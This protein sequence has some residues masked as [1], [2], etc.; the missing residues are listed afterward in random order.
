ML[1]DAPPPDYKRLNRDDTFAFSCHPGLTCFNTCCREKHLPLTPYDV[2]RMRQALDVHSDEFLERYVLYR[3]DPDTGFPVLSL[4]MNG[5]NKLCPFV[6][7]EG[8]RIYK[9]RPMA[10]RLYPLGRSST[11]GTDFRA[12]REFF[13]LLD[14]PGCQGIH[15]NKVQQVWEW[16]E[17]QGLLPYMEM[18]DQMLG[19]VFHPNRD[20]SRPLHQKQQQKLL[21]ACYNIDMFKELVES[22]RFVDTF[23]VDQ[24]TLD[25][26]TRDD[27][28]LL[29]LG[30]AY[31]N[32]AL[33]PEGSD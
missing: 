27:T 14:T 15:E 18:N 6:G 13:Y 17:S 8:C 1:L 5:E 31:L 12:P 4:K 7:G 28:A 26:V 33:F 19:L 10:C 2:L 3:T 30:F 23:H 9:H 24:S 25:T 32:I 29:R 22:P 21:V 11:I 16:A 20:R